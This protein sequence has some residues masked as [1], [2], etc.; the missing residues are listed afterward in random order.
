MLTQ[1]VPSPSTL[2]SA[3][4][5]EACI[6]LKGRRA[7]REVG[8]EFL[9]LCFCGS[10]LSGGSM[11]RLTVRADMAMLYVGQQQN[12]NLGSPESML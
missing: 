11:G 8:G 12:S 2:E 10:L 3:G 4:C 6:A 5:T 9:L 7:G 1:S